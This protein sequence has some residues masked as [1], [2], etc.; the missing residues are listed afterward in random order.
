MSS[1]IIA[2]SVTAI[3]GVPTLTPYTGAFVV[4]NI[5]D[6]VPS[7]TGSEITYRGPQ[8]IPKVF[9]VDESP[10]D[11]VALASSDTPAEEI[12]SITAA[13]TA[14]AG[15]GQGSAV[16]LTTTVNN[17]T[18]SATAGDSVL[19]PEAVA[20]LR[21][22]VQN[23]GAASAAVFPATGETIDGGSAN[24]SINLPSGARIEFIATTT[25]NWTTVLAETPKIK[26]YNKAAINATATATAAE[27][28]TGY[29]TSTSG[30]ATSITFPTGTLLGAA[31]GAVQGTIHDLYVDNTAGANTVTM[32]VGVNAIL[33]A[34]A[35]ANGASQGLL[36]IPSGVTG[37]ACF[38][39]MFSSATAYTITRIA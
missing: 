32:V 12:E 36:T 8:S 13:I 16:Q 19:L 2:L 15:G 5:G 3:K 18:V 14:H 1:P 9:T 38:R 26:K 10:S 11:I 4:D 34:A 28:A 33:S 31:L 23:Y 7:G 17:I 24:A 35:A 25:S 21:V 37:Q 27:V 20:G 30:A 39:L 22:V 29:L 6:I